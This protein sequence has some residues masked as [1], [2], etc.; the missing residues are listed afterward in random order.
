M[1]RR[2]SDILNAL[3]AALVVVVGFAAG[4]ASV[5]LAVRFLPG[6]R[7]PGLVIRRIGSSVPAEPAPPRPTRGP[8]P[9]PR[10]L[11]PPAA[12]VPSDGPEPIDGDSL[13]SLVAALRE[14]A[15]EVPVADVDPA[16]LRD[17]FNDPRSGFRIHQA[18]DILAPRG[19]PVVAVDDGTITSL[20]RSQGGGGIVVYQFDPG[21]EFVYYY[22]HL[23]RYASELAE[24]DHVK[25]GDVIGYV[26]TSGNAPEDTPHLHF[27]IFRMT[28]KKQWWQGTPIDPFDIL[29]WTGG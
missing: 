23:Q 12:T 21:G 26:G 15:L 28:D 25:R 22:A 9:A 6:A 20:D 10:A 5:A 29:G 1:R 18:L 14:R 7:E 13:A 17:D 2:P 8:E 19:T 11:P 16:D 4:G 3:P 24:G 27:A